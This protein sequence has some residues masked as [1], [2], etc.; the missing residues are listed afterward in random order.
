MRKL[1]IAMIAGGFLLLSGVAASAKPDAGTAGQGQNGQQQNQTQQDN[2]PAVEP[3]RKPAAPTTTKAGCGPA[4]KPCRAYDDQAGSAY[5]DQA[6][7]GGPEAGRD[8]GRVWPNGRQYRRARRSQLQR[9]ERASRC[10]RVDDRE[11]YRRERRQQR[12]QPTDQKEAA[13][14]ASFLLAP[15]HSA[16]F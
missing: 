15:P 1:F 9:P 2:K 12:E 6:D 14:A 11:R 13:S 8:D 16:Q 5:T 10:Q 4:T 7:Y 3:V